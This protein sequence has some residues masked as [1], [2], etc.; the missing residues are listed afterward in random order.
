MLIYNYVDLLVTSYVFKVDYINL[1]RANRLNSHE[2]AMDLYMDLKAAEY[3]NLGVV[4]ENWHLGLNFET[5]R[6]IEWEAKNYV[7]LLE[8]RRYMN[9]WYYELHII[10]VSSAVTSV[11]ICSC[12]LA[13]KV[14]L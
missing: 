14:F 13:A 8:Y 7:E 5:R 9:S 6:R 1:I 11:F 12:Y 4:V 3:T 10:A 2:V